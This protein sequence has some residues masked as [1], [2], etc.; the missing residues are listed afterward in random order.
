MNSDMSPKRKITY[1]IAR[2]WFFFLAVLVIALII[3]SVGCVI[4]V[5]V[6]N[7][8]YK[9]NLGRNSRIY[10]EKH[11]ADVYQLLSK[12]ELARKDMGK[13]KIEIKVGEWMCN[14]LSEEENILKK[15]GFS[16]EEIHDWEKRTGKTGNITLC[17]SNSPIWAGR[18][19]QKIAPGYYEV[20]FGKFE[21]PAL[22]SIKEIEKL[23]SEKNQKL[24][25]EGIRRGIKRS[26]LGGPLSFK[27]FEVFMPCY[28]LTFLILYIIRFT[29]WAI[30]TVKKK[31]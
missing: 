17:S 30:R 10:L 3:V 25:E 18:V 9:R 15:A 23:A 22:F 5:E 24:L 19:A 20:W 29:I 26:K 12:I 13:G 16:E 8:Q 21:F 31:E 4:F 7:I 27:D 6:S 11:S 1:Y 14:V 28:F 2:E